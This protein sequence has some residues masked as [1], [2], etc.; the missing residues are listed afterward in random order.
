[1]VCSCQEIAAD[2]QGAHLLI[3]EKIWQ[4]LAPYRGPLMDIILVELLQAAVDA[5]FG[6][7]RGECIA[8]ILVSVASV[9]VRG[10]VFTRLRKVGLLLEAD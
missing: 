8:D 3:Q 2:S 1:M 9:S 7:N 6:S 10:K 4:S 5:G